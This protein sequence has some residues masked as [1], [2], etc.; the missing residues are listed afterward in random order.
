MIDDIIKAGDKA[1]QMM[2]QIEMSW[3]AARLIAFYRLLLSFIIV[4]GYLYQPVGSLLG[5]DNSSIFFV[6]ANAYLVFALYCVISNHLRWPSL[7]FQI[8]LYSIIDILVVMIFMHTSGGLSS[9]I[10]VL[11]V[12]IVA[13]TGLLTEFRSAIAFAAGASLLVLGE[14]GFRVL[15]HGAEASY[16][17]QAGMLGVTLFI[18][19]LVFSVLAKRLRESEILAEKI[20]I[21]L[22]NMGQLNEYIIQRMGSGVLVVDEQMHIRLM[23]EAARYLLGLSAKKGLASLEQ[24]SKPLADQL[25]SWLQDSNYDSAVFRVTGS[26]AI[27]PR[28]TRLGKEKYA[29]ALILLEDTSMLDQ[30]AQ[31]M[32]MTAL[33]RLTASIAHEIRNP[34]GAISHAGQ[35]LEE[36]DNLDNA[37]KRLTQ[38]IREQSVRMNTIIENVMQLSRRDKSVPEKIQLDHWLKGFLNEFTRAHDVDINKIGLDISPQDV[39]ITFD[40]SH[41]HQI[42]SN[43]C[44]NGIRHGGDHKGV[45]LLEVQGGKSRDVQGAFL[46]VIDYGPGIDAEMASQIFEPFFTTATKGTGLGLYIA[47]ELAEANQ[48]HL[49]YV[50]IPTGGSCF[51]ITFANTKE[52]K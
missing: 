18:S 27:Y 45:H 41:L 4:I 16:F 15:K 47:R 1:G 49:D 12:V 10:G 34:L 26:V 3:K 28:F 14:H 48:A 50:P 52:R 39:E 32:K 22:E 33:G 37:D 44:Q 35:L 25:V 31:H 51:R 42:L 20:G 23:N 21:D 9:G 38:I 11:L 40:P 46:D 6:V 30:Q 8:Y 24:I 36:S 7:K 29:G 43:L 13:S 2:P 17:L 19:A 5:Y